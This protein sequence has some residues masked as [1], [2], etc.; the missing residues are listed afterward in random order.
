MDVSHIRLNRDLITDRL[1]SIP[2][3]HFSTLNGKSS[4]VAL[5]DITSRKVYVWTIFEHHF[6]Q[7]IM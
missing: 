4:I 1:G 6:I 2:R 5:L 3:Y 7:A